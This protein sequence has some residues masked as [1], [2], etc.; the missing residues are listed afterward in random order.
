MNPQN[1]FYANTRI[2]EKPVSVAS[3][4]TQQMIKANLPENPRILMIGAGQTNTLVTK[5]LRKY[6][7]SNLTVFNRTFENAQKLASIVGG[8]ALPYE[9]LSSYREGFDALIVCTAATKA[10]VETE[11]YTQLLNGETNHKVLVDLSVPNNID[12]R[13]AKEFNTTYIEIEGIRAIAQEN[14]AFRENEVSKAKVILDESLVTFQQVYQQRQIE[15]AMSEVPKAIKAIKAHA[16]D[17]VFRKELDNL[18]EN[19]LEL[20]ERMMSYME[21]QCISIPMKAA[22]EIIPT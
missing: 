11:L 3:L 17:N 1:R 7:L 8:R 9:H 15:K 6:K 12:R 19:T 5:F 10:I 14:H 21:K 18:D 4:A 13:I 22:K 2:G 20:M 16:M